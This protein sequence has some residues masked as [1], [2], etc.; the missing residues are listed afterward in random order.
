[1]KRII[2][3]G[4]AFSAVLSFLSAQTKKPGANPAMARGKKVYEQYCLTCHQV[5]GSG[6]PHLNPP[7]IKTTFVLGDKPTLVQVILKGMQS[8][9]PID[10]EY[11]SNNMPPHNFLK[12]Q[13]IADV[14]TY[15]RNN[16]GN[17]A[18]AVTA[19]EVKAIRAKN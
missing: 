7:L 2:L 19:A 10:D 16:F 18:S 4:V 5:D 8:S 14:L 13:E 6:V 3:T 11:Y 9:V 1:M 15:V 12:D 17:K